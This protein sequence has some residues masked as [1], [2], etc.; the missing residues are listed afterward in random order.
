M[1]ET[2]LIVE[3]ASIVKVSEVKSLVPAVIASI[4]NAVEAEKSGWASSDSSI[5]FDSIGASV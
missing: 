5:N 4:V 1:V 3:T 2:I